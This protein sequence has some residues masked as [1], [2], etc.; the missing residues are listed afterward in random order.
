MS[1]QWYIDWYNS[2]GQNTCP[3]C[4]EPTIAR[5]TPEGEIVIDLKHKAD[6][7][8]HAEF[9]LFEK[10]NPNLSSGMLWMA[11]NHRNDT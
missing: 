5:E 11:W 8:L 4:G 10:A 1:N 6:C 3:D 9:L 7:K 2:Q